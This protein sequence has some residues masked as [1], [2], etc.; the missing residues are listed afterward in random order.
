MS[1]QTDTARF[2]HDCDRC[3]FLG[4]RIRE[5]GMAGVD[6]GRYT[7]AVPGRTTMGYAV[8]VGSQVKMVVEG[9]AITVS[10]K[11]PA[12]ADPVVVTLTNGPT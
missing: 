8:A 12:Q 6:F 4:S 5:D 3:V 1:S 10:I 7:G 9:A 11:M 2:T